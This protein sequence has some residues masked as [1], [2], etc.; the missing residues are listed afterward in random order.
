MLLFV[1]LVNVVVCQEGD[2]AFAQKDSLYLIGNIVFRGNHK[3][4]TDY[5]ER[6]LRLEVGVIYPLELITKK[7]QYL[8]SLNGLYKVEYELL[9]TMLDD[10]HTKDLVI[11]V[12]EQKT[13]LPVLN[14]GS[15]EKY[16]WFQVGLV[17]INLGG[18]GNE[19]YTYYQNNSGRHSGQLIFKMPSILGSKVGF[20]LNLLSWS[21]LEPLN[22][23]DSRNIYNYDNRLIG[24]EI[25]Y[26]PSQYHSLIS[27]ISVFNEVY[28]LS[29][30][31]ENPLGPAFLDLSKY[32]Y[33]VEHRYR[34]LKYDDLSVKG[35]D[36][37]SS[38][39][40]VSTMELAEEFH[41]VSSQI[42]M[43]FPLSFFTNYKNKI[44]VFATRL[45][46]GT[47]TNNDSP[48]A[49]FYV[50]SYKNV[51]GVGDRIAR[52]TAIVSL[53]TELRQTLYSMRRIAAQAV[54]FVDVAA[55][56]TPGDSWKKLNYENNM[57]SYVGLGTRLIY[58]KIFNAVL[59][60]DY[61]VDVTDLTNRQFVIGLGQYF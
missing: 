7:V 1:S 45:S 55:L 3:T 30:L 51:R 47:S 36:W 31:E 15:V 26:R 49:P 8:S 57:V 37:L 40:Y 44:T 48:F 14:F 60:I 61:G 50:D 58:K 53:N 16:N 59:R 2:R 29:E 5:L 4:K 38:Y 56:R 23:G 25:M 32:L 28:K 12:Y 41:I 17:D 11:E 33:K 22:F 9:E 46:A 52:G 6:E 20:S 54:I 43:F 27:G 18:R 21:S 10:G 24:G 35:F 19:I 13:L 39:Q 34:Q 42:N